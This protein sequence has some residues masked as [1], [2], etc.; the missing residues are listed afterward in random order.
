MHGSS[1]LRRWAL[2]KTCRRRLRGDRGVT[3][4]MPWASCGLSRRAAWA[5]DGM[6][7][8]SVLRRWALTKTCQRRLRGERAPPR[9]LLKIGFIIAFG[10]ETAVLSGEWRV[11]ELLLRLTLGVARTGHVRPCTARRYDGPGVGGSPV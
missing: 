6:H 11:L 4:R 10:V 9:E 8:S 1:V 7:G 2:A 5:L 3:R